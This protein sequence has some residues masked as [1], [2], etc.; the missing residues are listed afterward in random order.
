MQIEIGIKNVIHT[1]Y[2]KS[3]KAEMR[4]SRSSSENRYGEMQ[5]MN[6]AMIGDN[7]IDVYVRINGEEVNRRYPTGNC[8]DTGVNLQKL[9]I[10]TA[11]ISV[12]TTRHIS[13]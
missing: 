11:I 9:G 5:N 3:L 12:A 1:I 2:E 7:C 10:P 4:I 6:T 13:T 8:V